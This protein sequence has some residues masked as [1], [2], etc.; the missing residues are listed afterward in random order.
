MRRFLSIPLVALASLAFASTADAKPVSY[1]GET[2]SVYQSVGNLGQIW[3]PDMVSFNGPQSTFKIDGNKSGG[4]GSKVYHTYGTFSADFKFTPGAGKGVLGLY[5]GI[6][7]QEIDFAELPKRNPTRNMITS[8]LHYSAANIM[9][10]YKLA[11]DYT[12]W[13]T[14]TVIWK[15]GD[16]T[17]QIDGV[18][19]GHTTIHVPDYPMHLAIQTAGENVAGPG[20]PSQLDV[21]NIT[22]TPLA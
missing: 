9:Q 1:A 6:L 3:S 21:T 19:Y 22:Y 13:H 16:L 17:F 15:P 2:W 5:G 18:T 7:H 8:T 11:G 20:A 12:Q 14:A 10:H 4:I